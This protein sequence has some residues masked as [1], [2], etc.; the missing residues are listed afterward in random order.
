MLVLR[1]VEHHLLIQSDKA[2]SG[3]RGVIASYGRYRATCNTPPCRHNHLGTFDTPEEAAQA[4]L[5]HQE[6]E[7]PEEL[8]AL[9]AR[10]VSTFSLPPLCLPSTNTTT[11]QSGGSYR[12]SSHPLRLMNATDETLA[13]II[14]SGNYCLDLNKNLAVNRNQIA[15]DL[16]YEKTGLQLPTVVRNGQVTLSEMNR[17]GGFCYGRDNSPDGKF[18][19]LGY[20]E[21]GK[22]YDA[23]EE[24]N[25]ISQNIS[26]CNFVYRTD[27]NL[28]PL[29]LGSF[30]KGNEAGGKP[31]PDFLHGVDPKGKSM[32]GKVTQGFVRC[33]SQ[34]G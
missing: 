8:G 21:E 23:L 29:K 13:D 6:E 10:E 33:R 25:L 9:Q 18:S 16:I 11:K 17:A 4:Y 1:E 20:A 26:T 30:R 14:A 34:W 24:Y 3:Y 19:G 28:L 32:E 5:Q 27:E 31:C 12:P 15:C 22:A 7:H 2:K